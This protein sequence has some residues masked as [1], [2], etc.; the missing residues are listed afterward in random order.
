[1][2]NRK[3]PDA[4]ELLRQKAQRRKRLARLSFEE[5]IA[6]VKKWRKLT[7]SIRNSEW[8]NAT[9]SLTESAAG[10]ARRNVD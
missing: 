6:V 4:T 3:Y 8:P 1:M 2:D 5:K 10:D 9:L 7:R